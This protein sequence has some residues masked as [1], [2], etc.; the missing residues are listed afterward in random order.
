MDFPWKRYH[1][2][3]PLIIHSLSEY[4]KNPKIKPKIKNYLKI[5]S[6]QKSFTF[7]KKQKSISKWIEFSQLLSHWAEYF[8]WCLPIP[9][10]ELFFHKFWC[11]KLLFFFAHIFCKNWI[12]YQLSRK[13]RPFRVSLTARFLPVFHQYQEL[14]MVPFPEASHPCRVVLQMALF[15]MF[16]VH[17]FGFIA[18]N[19]ENNIFF[20][21]SERLDTRHGQLANWWKWN[22]S[23]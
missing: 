21:H 18:K 2:Y 4:R 8:S 9:R 20:L 13:F 3:H 11:A 14:Q 6:N 12:F 22:T 5:K 16:P 23:R 15:P 7:P 10:W 1:K 17:D 19:G